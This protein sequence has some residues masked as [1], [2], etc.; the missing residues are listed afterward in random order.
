MVPGTR[1][2]GF[3]CMRIPKLSARAPT[4]P[5]DQEVVKQQCFFVEKYVKVTLSD[6]L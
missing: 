1:I 4:P 2:S 6:I 3:E 5:S